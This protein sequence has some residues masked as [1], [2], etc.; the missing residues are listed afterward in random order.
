V[1]TALK[2]LAASDS[3]IDLSNMPLLCPRYKYGSRFLGALQKEWH[4]ALRLANDSLR[5]DRLR[6]GGKQAEFR[7][8]AGSAPDFS[9]LTSFSLAVACWT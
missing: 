2:Q 1:A 3:P 7:P 9:L 6:L 8:D 5:L 4:D